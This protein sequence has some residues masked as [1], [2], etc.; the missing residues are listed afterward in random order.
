MATAS[1]RIAAFIVAVVALFLATMPTVRAQNTEPVQGTITETVTI[2]AQG[3]RAYTASLGASDSLHFSV[4]V[5]QG[6]SLDVYLLGPVGYSAYINGSQLSVLYYID[7]SRVNVTSFATT[8]SPHETGTYYLVL[9]NT[10]FPLTGSPGSEP[11]TVD[12][13][14]EIQG[15]LVWYVGIG[16][17]VAAAVGALLFFRWRKRKPKGVPTS[18]RDGP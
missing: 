6:S 5:L 17:A 13:T 18:N 14:A 12:V 1:P 4:R 10:P 2:P 9:D 11:V 7:A 8:F 3:W 16:A 15:L